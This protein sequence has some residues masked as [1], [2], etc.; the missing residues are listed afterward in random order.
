MIDEL[1]FDEHEVSAQPRSQKSRRERGTQGQLVQII[2]VCA[3]AANGRTQV[4][5][6]APRSVVSDL[7]KPLLPTSSSVLQLPIDCCPKC[8]L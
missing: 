3:K 4:G 7:S 6:C 2:I 5:F 1:L 8:A